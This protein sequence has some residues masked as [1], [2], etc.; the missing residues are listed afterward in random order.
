MPPPADGK[1]WTPQGF[2]ALRLGPGDPD[3]PLDKA[4][5]S[6]ISSAAVL[7]V[8]AHNSKNP[9]HPL[10]LGTMKQDKQEVKFL[11]GEGVFPPG[12]RPALSL[13]EGYLVL[14]SSPEA[15][16]RFRPSGPAPG[17]GADVP[18][19]RV[20]LKD[21]RTYLRQRRDPLAAAL[22]AKEEVSRE[23][24]LRHL[25]AVLSALRFID[26][27]ELRHRTQGG[28][29]VFTLLVRPAQPLKP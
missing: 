17:P 13:R 15:L 29:A 28:R 27:V 5:L 6:A 10:A 1:A 19:L 21:C 2:A 18:L 24:A 9:E 16:L 23:E 3:A 4:V 7:L 14:A 11:S 25:D 22:A 8:V 20:S 12:V 26:R